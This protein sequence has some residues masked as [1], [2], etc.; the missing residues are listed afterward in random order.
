MRGTGS[1]ESLPQLSFSEDFVA[2]GML[3]LAARVLGLRHGPQ[4]VV[5]RE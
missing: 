4:G 2:M 1:G 3:L 5:Y